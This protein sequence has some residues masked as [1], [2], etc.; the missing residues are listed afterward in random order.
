MNLLDFFIVIP[1][2]FFAYRGF[3][4]GVIHEVMNIVGIVLA[5]FITFEYMHATSVLFNPLFDNPDHS[6]VAA[7][8]V[9]FIATVAAVQLIA[10][11]IQKLLKVIKI[12]FINRLAGLA[13]GA[14]K[15]GIVVSAFLLL[16]AGFNLPGEESRNESISYPYVIYLAPAAFNVVATVYPGAEN[17]IDTIEQSIEENNPIKS[18]PIF[19]GLSL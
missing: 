7:G 16:L 4:S 14:L 8:I 11:A 6:V 19:E 17:F 12:N 13:F 3:M 9:L 10:Y 5:V 15:S 1:I 18:L 2:G